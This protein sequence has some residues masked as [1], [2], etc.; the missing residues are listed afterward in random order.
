MNITVTV[1]ICESVISYLICNRIRPPRGARCPGAPR[2]QYGGGHDLGPRQITRRTGRHHRPRRDGDDRGRRPRERSRI[3]VGS[4][5]CCRHRTRR[6]GGGERGRRVDAVRTDQ[7][8]PRGRHPH[9]PGPP[10]ARRRPVDVAR[11]GDPGCRR[12]DRRR[13]GGVQA[14]VL[15]LTM[16]D[17]DGAGYA[18]VWPTGSPMPTVSS[19]NTDLAGQ[20]VA[21]MV[22]VPL[23]V[24]GFISIFSSIGAD[25]IVDVQGVYESA[26]TASAGRFVPLTPRRAIDTR[27]SASLAPDSSITVDVAAVGVPRHA[28][29]AVLNVTATQTRAGGFLTVWPA[30]TPMPVA[31][32]LN[33]PRAGYTVANQVIARVTNGRVSVYSFE[34]TDVI[35]DVTGYMTGATAPAGSDGLYVPITPARLLDTVHRDPAAAGSRSAR[36]PR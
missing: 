9:R 34:R 26:T 5:P 24:D 27:L 23:G 2:H 6:A 22:T 11:P 4:G 30:D 17:V 10:P 14:V 33:V 3:D 8:D 36:A 12:R 19:P 29:A 15:N 32:N 16:V 28:S 7:P 25:Y 20:T 1:P 35:V 21:N 13:A 18:S 31:S